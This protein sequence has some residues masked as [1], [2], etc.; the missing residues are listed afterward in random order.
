MFFRKKSRQRRQITEADVLAYLDQQADQAAIFSRCMS[1]AVRRKFA[2][3]LKVE[4][5]G[6][7]FKTGVILPGGALPEWLADW[8]CAQTLAKKTQADEFRARMAGRTKKGQEAG[9][10][11]QTPLEMP[12]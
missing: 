8:A 1:A 4:V 3:V 5:D 10:E 6:V 11:E 2:I 7:E 9:S 12:I